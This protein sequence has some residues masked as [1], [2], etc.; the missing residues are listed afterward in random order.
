MSFFNSLVLYLVIWWLSLFIF[1]P[2]GI[3]KQKNIETGNDPGAP[4]DPGL[5]KKNYFYINLFI[6]HLVNNIYYSFVCL[7]HENQFILFAY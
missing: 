4:E 6:N 7:N 5:K 1:L 2:L 3:T